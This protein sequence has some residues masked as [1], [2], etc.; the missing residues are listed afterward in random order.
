M[1][2]ED[3]DARARDASLI[4]GLLSVF[5]NFGLNYEELYFGS[6]D[7]MYEFVGLV[8]RVRSGKD[9]AESYDAVHNDW[10]VNLV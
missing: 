7:S 3:E 2:V 8:G 6:L 9:A 4:G 10:V 1:I 5:E